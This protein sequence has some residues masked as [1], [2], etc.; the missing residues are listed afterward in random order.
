M[1]AAVAHSAGAVAEIDE[2]GYT[3]RQGRAR[4]GVGGGVL[5]V[6]EGVLGRDCLLSWFMTSNQLPG[7]VAQR[8]HADDEMYPL[9]RPHRP[10]LC[11][12]LIALCDFTADNG[13][14]RSG[15]QHAVSALLAPRTRLPLRNS[16]G[17]GQLTVT[18][19]CGC[20]GTRFARSGCR[21]RRRRRTP[22][23][24]PMMS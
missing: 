1:T 13:A 10:L 19:N 5:P 23:R 12:A 21:A 20:G 22:H 14:T 16:H 18:A 6:V 17:D 7:A 9:A 4:P 2:L 24:D 15:Q 8:L 11:N 3:R